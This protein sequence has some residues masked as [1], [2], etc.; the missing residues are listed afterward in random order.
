MPK[1]S[2]GDRVEVIRPSMTASYDWSGMRGVVVG[3]ADTMLGQR[4]TVDLDYPPRGESNSRW[5]F[6]ENALRKLPPD[7]HQDA[8]PRWC[9]NLFDIDMDQSQPVHKPVNSSK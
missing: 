3:Y 4:V 9:R 7:D 8:M 5:N 2:A 1:F 6:V